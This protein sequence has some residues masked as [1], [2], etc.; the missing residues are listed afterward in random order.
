[1]PPCAIRSSETQDAQNAGYW[2]PWGGRASIKGTRLAQQHG[3]L[4]VYNSWDIFVRFKYGRSAALAT[5]GTHLIGAPNA[6]L[7]DHAQEHDTTYMVT[8][9]PCP[10]ASIVHSMTRRRT[11]SR[12]PSWAQNVA[13]G[14]KNTKAKGYAGEASTEAESGT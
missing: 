4:I 14:L 9:G 8:A 12:R 7:A 1:M 13:R 6:L 11:A 5:N 3:L 2:F 10:P